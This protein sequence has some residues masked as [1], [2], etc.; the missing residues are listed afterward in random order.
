MD[1]NKTDGMGGEANIQGIRYQLYF[2]IYRFL[3]SD[4]NEILLEW[5]DEDVVI[6]NEDKAAPSLELIQCKYIGAG[7]LPFSKFY[8]EIFRNFIQIFEKTKKDN[9]K[10]KYSFTIVCNKGLDRN[11]DRFSRIPQ[12][13]REGVPVESIEQLYY[14]PLLSKI[15]NKDYIKSTKISVYYFLQF[16]FFYNNYT[17]KYLIEEIHKCLISFGCSN[18][19]TDTERILS[20][21]INIGS[22]KITKNQLKNDLELDY[23][24]FEIQTITSSHFKTELTLNNI[25]KISDEAGETS[26]TI[27]NM[28]TNIDGLDKIINLAELTADQLTYTKNLY[29]IGKSDRREIERS[30]DD[31]IE[32]AGDVS[33]SIKS[34]KETMGTISTKMDEIKFLRRKYE[35]E[36]KGT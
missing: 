21:F 13:L 19:N 23:P 10:T 15:N 24:L 30:S 4:S 25:K 11:M 8:N 2:A 29:P 14:R 16:L 26:S 28:F 17:Q 31:A 34:M 3:C 18:P 22:G 20:Y 32:I 27:N 1:M 5:L 7:G 36:N 9:P 35:L 12:R 33:K 6:V